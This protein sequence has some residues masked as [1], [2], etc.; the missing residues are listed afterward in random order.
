MTNY[1]QPCS[2]CAYKFTSFRKLD[3]TRHRYYR[4]EAIANSP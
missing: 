4:K 3:T 2:N 1:E